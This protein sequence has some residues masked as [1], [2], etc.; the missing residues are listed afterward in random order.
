MAPVQRVDDAAVQ[1]VTGPDAEQ[2]RTAD[3]V[4]VA[5]AQAHAERTEK[6]RR[7]QGDQQRN[8]DPARFEDGLDVDGVGALH[9]LEWRLPRPVSEHAC[10]GLRDRERLVRKA[11]VVV[12]LQL[13][14]ALEE[15]ELSGGDQDEECGETGPDEHR[16]HP[17][18]RAAPSVPQGIDPEDD[19]GH[20]RE[21]EPRSA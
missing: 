21:V 8:A 6:R 12:S 17:P 15:S 16:E 7:K 10:C 9:E 13:R 18:E 1:E 11:R 20:D 4:H 3:A 5:V 19:G 2:R 14:A